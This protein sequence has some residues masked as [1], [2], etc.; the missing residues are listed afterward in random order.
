MTICNN[1]TMIKLLSISVN[2]FARINFRSAVHVRK[3]N[4]KVLIGIDK[5]KIRVIFFLF[6]IFINIFLNIPILE[7]FE[8]IKF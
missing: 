6:R 5:S 1:Q 2:L 4:L 3:M 7:S 8:H